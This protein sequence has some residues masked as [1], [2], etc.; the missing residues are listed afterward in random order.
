MK[1]STEEIIERIKNDDKFKNK[2]LAEILQDDLIT[3]KEAVS[4]LHD[5]LDLNKYKKELV[6]VIK[7]ASKTKKEVYFKCPKLL[8]YELGE[9]VENKGYY[10]ME[11]DEAKNW[12]SPSRYF[13]HYGIRVYW[14]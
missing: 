3:P 9:F 11:W 5:N 12:D 8:L 13:Q 7:E 14:Y 1:Y 10:Y 6:E 2:V 4:N